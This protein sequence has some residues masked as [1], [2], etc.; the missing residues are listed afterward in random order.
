MHFIHYKDY[1]PINLDKVGTIGKENQQLPQGVALY[2]IGF[3]EFERK[4]GYWVFQKE[5]ERDEVFQM[6]LSQVS[7][8]VAKKRPDSSRQ[9]AYLPG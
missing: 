3:Y 9:P 1:Q 8:E 2:A 7:K 6:I 4:V 5:Q